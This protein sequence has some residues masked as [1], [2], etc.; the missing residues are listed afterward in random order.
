MPTPTPTPTPTPVPTPTP[1]IPPPVAAPAALAAPAT[2]KVALVSKNSVSP[3]IGATA[4]AAALNAQIARH[5]GPA[6]GLPA[7]QVYPSG[8]IPAGQWGIILTDD[9]D[10]GHPGASLGYREVSAAGTPLGH[11]FVR[12]TIAAGLK[13]SV[14]A[15]RILI[16]ML[17]NPHGGLAA[18]GLDGS[19]IA[20]DPISPVRDR[21]YLLNGVVVSDFV[22]PAWYQSDRP[23][24]STRFSLLKSVTAPFAKTA[25]GT[26]TTVATQA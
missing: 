22:F 20:V 16:G 17:T 11:L 23:A 4:L 5:V 14:V 7:V 2:I 8:G 18:Q 26:I 10:T 21:T 12:P 15:S 6:W 25:G 13:V 3:G 9:P 19:F 24:G 1:T